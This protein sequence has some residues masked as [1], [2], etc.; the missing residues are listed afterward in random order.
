[1]TDVILVA[2]ANNAAQ[3]RRQL[4]VVLRAEQVIVTKVCGQPRE[5]LLHVDALTVPLGEPINCE[6]MARIV[7]SRPNATCARFDAC[8]S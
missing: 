6:A 1:M 4:K 8:L 5:T 3:L 7:G 2:R